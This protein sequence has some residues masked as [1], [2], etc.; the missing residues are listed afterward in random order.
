MR[1]QS[2]GMLGWM[3]AMIIFVVIF[4]GCGRDNTKAIVG[5][6][7]GVEGKEM[8]EFLKDGNMNI[9]TGIVPSV[10]GGSLGIKVGGVYRFVGK[11]QIWLMGSMRLLKGSD[12]PVV[13]GVS[14]SKNELILTSPDG[15]VAK[16]RR[17]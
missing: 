9:T 7:K 13:C 11:D 4:C 2:K 15:K 17:R 3:L 1:E 6:W 16:Y 8:L 5:K 12:L 14:V 10:D